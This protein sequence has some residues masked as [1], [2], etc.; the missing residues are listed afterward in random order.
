MGTTVGINSMIL[1]GVGYSWLLARAKPSA[2]MKQH[3]WIGLLLTNIGL[4]GFFLLLLI[5]GLTR[6]IGTLQSGW[7]FAEMRA[8][9]G[10]LLIPAGWFAIVMFLGLLTLA[11]CW[12]SMALRRVAPA[13]VSEVSV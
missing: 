7:S 13:T 10:H 9:I 12:L 4:L 5:I 2:K 11:T 1:F 6:G 3:L 8:H